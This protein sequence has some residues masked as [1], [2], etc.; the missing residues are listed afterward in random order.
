MRGD[1]LRGHLELLL[2]ACLQEGPAHGYVIM[3]RLRGRSGGEFDL[4]EGTIYPLLRRLEHRSLVSSRW[5]T[6][7]G[8]QRRVYKLTP[9]GRRGVTQGKQDWAGFVR[10][11]SAVLGASP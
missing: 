11:V 1:V 10:A 4:P 9:L 2:L 3:E 7:S 8:R 5:E 6:A